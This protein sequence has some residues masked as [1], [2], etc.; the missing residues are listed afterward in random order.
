[1]T[2]IAMTPCQRLHEETE[3]RVGAISVIL[4][5]EGFEIGRFPHADEVKMDADITKW[6]AANPDC[7]VYVLKPV[8]RYAAPEITPAVK[9]EVL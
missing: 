3:G 4:D 8:A 7:V 2:T 1:M 5:P 6:V 9:V